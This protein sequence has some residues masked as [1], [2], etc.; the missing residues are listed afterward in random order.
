[1]R[2]YRTKQFKKLFAKL[3]VATQKAAKESF[4]LWKENINH[5]SIEFKCIYNDHYSAR[6]SD[7]YRVF[8]KRG[9]KDRIVWYWIGSHSD[10]NHIV[11]H[12][13]KLK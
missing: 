7:N 8:G 12:L 10:Y 2:S 3:P 9:P 5:P 6:V 1:M 4:A 13:R 11:N